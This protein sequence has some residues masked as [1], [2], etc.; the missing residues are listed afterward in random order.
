[1]TG[2]HVDLTDIIN[3]I[4]RLGDCEGTEVRVRSVDVAVTLFCV[5]Q[6]WGCTPLLSS[7]L[8]VRDT[9]SGG[10]MRTAV[11][12]C[13]VTLRCPQDYSQDLMGF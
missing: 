2:Q 7:R 11:R 10:G 5:L 1:M 6:N 9:G 12:R 13:F 3:I 8:T 4:N